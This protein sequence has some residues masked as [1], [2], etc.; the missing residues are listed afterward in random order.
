MRLASVFTPVS[1][2]ARAHRSAA[3]PGSSANWA[4]AATCRCRAWGQCKP[5]RPTRAHNNR[6]VGCMAAAW[7]HRC[8]HS[9]RT[10]APCMGVPPGRCAGTGPPHVLMGRLQQ[11]ACSLRCALDCAAREGREHPARHGAATAVRPHQLGAQRYRCGQRILL[12]GGCALYQGG[13]RQQSRGHSCR[14]HACKVEGPVGSSTLP[15]S[16]SLGARHAK[17]SRQS[18]RNHT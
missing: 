12:P 10:I 17:S 14:R 18:S 4:R 7:P 8:S 16:Q 13:W 1:S 3:W 5:A 9:Q 6:L 15:A 11:T 2:S